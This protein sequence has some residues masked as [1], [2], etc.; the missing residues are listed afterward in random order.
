MV[1][2]KKT[3]AK[4]N[5]TLNI[6]SGENMLFNSLFIQLEVVWNKQSEL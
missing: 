5:L 2:D 1:P 6:L 4:A 3:F